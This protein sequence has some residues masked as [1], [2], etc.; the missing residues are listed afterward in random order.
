MEECVLEHH[1]HQ[2][3]QTE[4]THH[5]HQNRKSLP[6]EEGPTIALRTAT[7]SLKATKKATKKATYTNL[8]SS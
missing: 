1:T 8:A 6:E 3:H 2:A 4:Q 7:T 5:T